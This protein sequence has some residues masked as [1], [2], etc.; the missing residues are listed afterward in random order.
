MFPVINATGVVIHTNLGRAPLATEAL[1]A[2]RA[3][4]GYANLEMDLN[5]GRRSSRHEH[6]D[7]LIAEVS[8]A[9]AGVVINNCAGAVLLALAAV[10]EGA[11]VIV[12]RGELVEIGGGFRVPDVVAQSG[13]KLIE[14]GTTN[15]THLRDYE[16]AYRDNPD[17]RVILRTHPSNFRISGFT[18][19]PPLDALAHFAHAHDLLLVEDLGGGAL[20]DLSPFGIANEPTVQASLRAGVDLV[21]FSGD[22]LLGGPQAGIAAGRRALTDR[23]AAHPLA[24]A[25][26]LDKLSLAALAATLRLYLPPSDPIRRVPVLRMLTEDVA[27]LAARADALMAQVA[28]APEL[29][30]QVLETLGYAGGG[31]MPMHALPGLAIALSSLRHSADELAHRLRTGPIRVLGRIENDQVL[32]DLRTVADDELPALAQAIRTAS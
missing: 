22:K 29:E 25:M 20:V 32:L 9:E 31:A 24:R 19:S 17:A 6:L 4:A 15:R 23:M 18:S 14:V 7:R 2:M 3:A 27:V 1:A 10:A 8:G 11:P 12:S 13:S 26:R 5:T 21:L 30:L 16:Q 28:D